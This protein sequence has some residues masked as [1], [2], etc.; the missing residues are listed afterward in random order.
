MH[1]LGMYTAYKLH[2]CTPAHV[3]HVYMYAARVLHTQYIHIARMLYTKNLA[4]GHMHAIQAYE[5]MYAVCVQLFTCSMYVVHN[6][7]F[8]RGEPWDITPPHPNSFLYTNFLNRIIHQ[9]QSNAPIFFI[10]FR[11]LTGHVLYIQHMIS[12]CIYLLVSKVKPQ[13]F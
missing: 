4:Q 5:E 2:M 7:C 9:L 11:S 6:Q 10:Y 3:T 8:I 1:I 13:C 12:S